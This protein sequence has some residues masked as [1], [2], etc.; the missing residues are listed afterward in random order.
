MNPSSSFSLFSFFSIILYLYI[1]CSTFI[2]HKKLIEQR[3]RQFH[4]SWKSFEITSVTLLS[5]WI[6]SFFLFVSKA[7]TD[8]CTSNNLQLIYYALIQSPCFCAIYDNWKN[9]LKNILA[10]LGIS[11]QKTFFSL[12][13]ATH[14][15]VIRFL[16]SSFEGLS[17]FP[18]MS[19]FLAI[20]KFT[21][22]PVL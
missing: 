16:Y 1:L 3:P 19:L 10:V 9:I 6:P 21:I 2:L 18:S 8:H 11:E 17:A 22:G 5:R 13:K 4:C 7:N 14:P 15:W 20:G 12:L